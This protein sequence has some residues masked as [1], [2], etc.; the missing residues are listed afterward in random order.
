MRTHTLLIALISFST[1]ILSI[2]SCSMLPYGAGHAGRDGKIAADTAK[3]SQEQVSLGNYKK[4]LDI[5]ARAYDRHHSASLR[6]GFSRLGEQLSSASDKAYQEA[7]YAEA[8]ILARSLFESGITT[9]DFA[10][11]LSFDD[12]SLTTRISE[13]SRSLMELGLIRY[14]EEKLGEAISIWKKAL[15]FDADNRNVKQAIDTATVQ[16]N[17]LK[18]I[19]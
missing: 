18:H 12:D 10:D 15:A 7:R 1:A 8:G 6:Q 14:R 2:P 17:Q 16:L 4:A 13:C 9:R 19:K 5:Y 11:R 3:R